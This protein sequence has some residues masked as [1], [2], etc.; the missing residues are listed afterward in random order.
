MKPKRTH[1]QGF[2]LIELLIVTAVGGFIMATLV[3]C[4][5]LGLKLLV[6]LDERT[7]SAPGLQ[8]SD[9]ANAQLDASTTLPALMREFTGDLASSKLSDVDYTNTMPC[10]PMASDPGLPTRTI[11]IK[12]IK[13]MAS[14]PPRQVVYQYSADVPRRIAEV[15]RYSC[16]LDGTGTT[17][18]VVARGLNSTIFPAVDA[19]TS[20]GVIRLRVVSVTGRSFTVD[21]YPRVPS[22]GGSTP[23]TGQ[24]HTALNAYDI[25]ADAA[26]DRLTV[27]FGSATPE[28]VCTGGD[29]V[30]GAAYWSIRPVAGA[31][32]TRADWS[33][34][35]V[36]LTI[37][38]ARSQDTTVSGLSLSFQPPVGCTRL[39]PI[40]DA[41]PVDNAPAV[42]VEVMHGSGAPTQRNGL[43]ETGDSLRLAFS[44]PVLPSSL[45]S[46]GK[47][48]ATLVSTGP[49]TEV[50][51]MVDTLMANPRQ[52]L[53]P[54]PV[55]TQATHFM[56]G[57]GA[58]SWQASVAIDALA[59]N[60]V[61][62]TLDAGG[63]AGTCSGLI[64][65]PTGALDP[66]TPPFSVSGFDGLAARALGMNPAPTAAIAFRLW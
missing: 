21:G 5:L 50:F 25:D 60:V 54:N 49:S 62:V 6:G 34:S 41:T 28:L 30:A 53:A 3:A 35:N 65:A 42:L 55:A 44:E 63:C 51:T 48:W 19:P 14:G 12:T 17:A 45:P 16:A 2:T 40:R 57:L 29:P 1:D 38:G 36:N 7:A 61:T 8:N 24:L 31:A 59:T 52:D 43:M 11:L 66:L 18:A 26:L 22:S 4:M 37:A 32:V 47:T 64:A 56:A 10:T 46:L 58:V 39:A 13:M 23:A 9:A 15:D 33:G 20:R 27:G